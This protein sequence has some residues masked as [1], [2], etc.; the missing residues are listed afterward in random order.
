MTVISRSKIFSISNQCYGPVC[1][2]GVADQ[3]SDTVYTSPC[4]RRARPQVWDTVFLPIEIDIRLSSLFVGSLFPST[5]E[6]IPGWPIPFTA[7]REAASSNPDD[8]WILEWIK[9]HSWTR[10]LGFV[11]FNIETPSKAQSWLTS[12]A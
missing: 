2:H 6:A 12:Q 8:I 1:G 7:L 3:A 5:S 11:S 10:P 4:A 9:T